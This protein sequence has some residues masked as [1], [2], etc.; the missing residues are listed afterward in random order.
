[1]VIT[2]LLYL[3]LLIILALAVLKVDVKNP[4]GLLHKSADRDLGGAP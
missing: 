2:M 4:Q 3:T 1:M